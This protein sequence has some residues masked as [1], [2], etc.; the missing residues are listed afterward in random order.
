MPA[1]DF[2]LVTNKLVLSNL[3]EQQDLAAPNMKKANMRDK[4]MSEETNTN[5]Q[6]WQWMACGKVN[7]KHTVVEKIKI[8]LINGGSLSVCSFG[9]GDLLMEQYSWNLTEHVITRFRRRPM[10]CGIES[11]WGAVALEL[12]SGQSRGQL[13][14]LNSTTAVE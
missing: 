6:H 14:H 4:S 12:G 8:Q 13:R 11:Q 5:G 3:L 2:M 9:R 7:A 1:V 10:E